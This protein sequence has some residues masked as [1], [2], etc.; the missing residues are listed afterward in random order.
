MPGSW[1]VARTP[2]K[3]TRRKEQELSGHGSEEDAGGEAEEHD[4]DHRIYGSHF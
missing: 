1:R 4:V 3:E 2:A